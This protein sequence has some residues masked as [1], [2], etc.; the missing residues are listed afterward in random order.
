MSFVSHL[1]GGERENDLTSQA[2]LYQAD[3]EEDEDDEG[4]E[5]EFDDE[6]E[7]EGDEEVA[8]FDVPVT[9]FGEMLLMPLLLLDDWLLLSLAPLMPPILLLFLLE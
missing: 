3:E 1:S 7:E 4:G 5:S 8:P 6:E 2:F 9:C